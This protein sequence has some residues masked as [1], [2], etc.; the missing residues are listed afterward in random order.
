MAVQVYNVDKMQVF[1]KWI[2]IPEIEIDFEIFC[3]KFRWKWLPGPVSCIF[4]AYCTFDIIEEEI[5]DKFMLCWELSYWTAYSKH[6]LHMWRNYH[7][8]IWSCCVIYY[9]HLYLKGEIN[10]LIEKRKEKECK[11]R[12]QDKMLGTTIEQL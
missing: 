2:V 3:C 6:Y 5:L 11:D 10:L 9:Y 1:P 7:L 4:N 8:F 12:W